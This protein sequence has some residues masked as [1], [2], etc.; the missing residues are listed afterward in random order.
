MII[1]IE[2]SEDFGLD[3]SPLQD[4]YVFN[5]QEEVDEWVK[6]WNA[7]CSKTHEKSD[8]KENWWWGPKYAYWLEFKTPKNYE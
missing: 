2:N 3:S 1:I 7:K 8:N 4:F 5:T 6:E